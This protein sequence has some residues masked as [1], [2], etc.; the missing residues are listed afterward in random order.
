MLIDRIGNCCKVGH[1]V[2]AV[3]FEIFG[4][5]H[6]VYGID[7]RLTHMYN[8]A[9]AARLALVV[10]HLSMARSASDFF[11]GKVNLLSFA[12]LIIAPLLNV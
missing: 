5:I 1:T 4:D 10:C 12:V 6:T 2:V 8:G 3:E 7:V 9:A 11:P